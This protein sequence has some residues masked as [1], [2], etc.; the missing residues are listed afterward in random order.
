M[1]NT[2]NQM[3]HKKSPGSG[4]LLIGGAI[5]VGM[6]AEA[7]VRGGADFLLALNA[8]RYRVMG[9]ASLAALL[10]LGNA[11]TFTDQFAR[12][13]ILDRV[14]VPVL[15]GA[16][17]FDPSTSPE[18][19]VRQTCDVGYQGIAN[20]PSSIHFDG[21]FRQL[22]EEADLGF[23]REARMLAQARRAG[24]LTFGYAKTRAEISMLIDAGVDMI[25]LN[26]GWN[27]GGVQAVAQSFTIAEAADR[28]RRIFAS[29]RSRAPQTLCFV[30][31]G[32]I[33][34]PDDMFRVCD[35]ASADG[36]VGGSTLDRV[37]L[38]ISVTERTS[39]FKAFGL[40]KQANTAQTRELGRAARIA[41]IVGQSEFVLAVLEQV[42]RLA[43][44]RIPALICGEPGL[45]RGALARALHPLSERSGPLMTV[46]AKNLQA[47][48]E[49]QLFGEAPRRQGML[50]KPD[51]TVVVENAEVLPH[52]V[53]RRLVDWLEQ[54]MPDTGPHAGPDQ[55]ARLVLVCDAD[56][57]GATALI[58]E[59]AQCLQAGR[60]EIPPLRERPEDVPAL[61]RHRLAILGGGQQISAD[62]YRLLLAH[63]WP[64]NIPELRSVIDRAALQ[65]AGKTIGSGALSGAIGHSPSGDT[66]DE[67]P[68]LH[69]LNERD[70]LLDALRRNRFRRGDTAAY[71]GV[72]RKTLYNKM[73]R[74]GLL[75]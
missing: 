59:L 22:L 5:G 14:S 37:P 12:R 1:E 38:E 30:E 20:F 65:S 52:A 63:G 51:A 46:R 26:F 57:G 53:Q 48:P 45:G 34:N 16:S 67:D 24:L 8:G 13:E 74:M 7:A 60:I 68:A 19:L 56:P 27:A 15:F 64:G 36:Y 41:G 25:C 73:R 2:L 44:T 18:K 72:S 31:G 49:A 6:T 4:T 35:E 50:A 62:G 58:P 11:N 43:G 54:A 17:C 29:I 32:P 55:A 71:L 47:A 69:P 9:A 3:L 23:A 75:E 66:P 33:I 39:A 21:R 28:A 42:T 70:W 10:P 61:A 40:L